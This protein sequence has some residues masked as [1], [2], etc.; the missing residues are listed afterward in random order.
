MDSS[1][2]SA[3]VILSLFAGCAADAGSPSAGRDGTPALAATRS[4]SGGGSMAGGSDCD[5]GAAAMVG[6]T[7]YASIQAAIDAVPSGEIVAVCP[8]TWHEALTIDDGASLA[9]ASWSGS[10]AD[11]VLDGQD[12]HQILRTGDD[13]DLLVSSLSFVR[14]FAPTTRGPL[15][16]DGDGGAIQL[17]SGKLEVESCVFQG[18]VA[19]Y[20]GGAIESEDATA[21]YNSAFVGN[22]SGYDGGAVSWGGYG[23]EPAT[24]VVAGSSFRHNFADNA[25][26]SLSI[27]GS[28]TAIDV[29]ITGSTFQY[30]GAGYSGGAI[31]AGG[32]AA[33]TI[34]VSSCTFSRS[35][36]GYEGGAI[37]AGSWDSTDLRIEDSTFRANRATYQ[38]G[39]L[40]LGS[41]GDDLWE[42]DGVV[43]QANSAGSGG[44]IDVGTWGTAMIWATDTT[45]RA[46][47]SSGGCSA[48]CLD[49]WAED[50]DAIF[51]DTIFDGN[52]S[53]DSDSTIGVGSRVEVGRVELASCELRSNTG[54]ALSL[55]DTFE[56]DVSDTDFGTGAQ[57]NSP[58]DFADVGYAVTGL[59]DGASFSC[60]V[61]GICSGL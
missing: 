58:Y 46:N 20:S 3:L 10:A 2:V 11:T 45:F 35:R 13:V 48:V 25:G 42:L 61:G 22:S 57:A 59:G 8:G 30:E 1:R 15:G 28:D 17:A 32:W 50:I 21:I 16:E 49:G 6:P 7:G 18:N 38:G 19:D 43:F 33:A 31:D 34:D 9:L 55:L 39:A 36:A 40:S 26:G 56:A 37:A 52:L 27:G 60:E 53:A 14:G 47:R 24:L 12:D 5:S 51:V 23:G 44:A 54:T 4:A 29:S 41:W